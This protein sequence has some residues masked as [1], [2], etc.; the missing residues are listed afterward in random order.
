M[1]LFV[2]F[3]AAAAMAALALPTESFAQGAMRGGYGMRYDTQTV[4]TVS[5]EVI[6]VEKVAYGRRGHYGV[7]LVLKTAQGELQV[8]LGPSWFVNRQPMK[9]RPHDAI[10]VTGS[11]VTRQGK[12]A[13]IAAEVKKGGEMLRLREADGLPLWRRHKGGWPR[14]R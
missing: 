11:R 6:A 12:P 2:A 14:G 7:H 3:A 8:D 1:R 13:L 4:E 10:E 5:G 9:I